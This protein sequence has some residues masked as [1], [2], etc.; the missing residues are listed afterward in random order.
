MTAACG[1]A[2]CIIARLLAR[3]IFCRVACLL[4]AHGGLSSPFAAMNAAQFFFV[5]A[6]AQDFRG[7]NLNEL[8]DD[9]RQFV[10]RNISS[11]TKLET[12]LLL[13]GDREREWTAEEVSHALRAAVRG[14]AEQLSE[15]VSAGLVYLTYTPEARY[16]YR[17]SAD[18]PLD[19]LIGR[20]AEIYQQRRVAVISL[21]YSEP[22]NKARSFADSFRIR[23]DKENR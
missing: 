5:F 13:R 6:K 21:I 14:M 1:F 18:K 8:P 16:R 4:M 3:R 23:K 9:V 11:V 20:L 15:L 22:L 2:R 19:S 17:P 10:A 7:R 12:L